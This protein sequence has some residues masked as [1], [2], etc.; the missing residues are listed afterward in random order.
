MET[1]MSGAV[2]RI[3]RNVLLAVCFAVGAAGGIQDRAV[4]QPAAPAPT[5]APSV[6]P[7]PAA[8]PAQVPVPQ[9]P[10]MPTPTGQAVPPPAS[11]AAPQL[12]GSGATTEPVIPV[13]RGGYVYLPEGRRD[14]FLTILRESGGGSGKKAEELHLPPLQ[15]VTVAELSVIG[16]I[17]GGFG[18][19]AMVQTSDGKGYTV[20]RGTRIGNNNGVVSAITEK[21]VIVEERFTDIYGKKQV[22]EYAK[23]LHAKEGLP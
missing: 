13:G 15:R 7:A 10:V 17:W 11:S 3:V 19:T 2:I 1:I 9:A 22:R 18:Y 4:A 12:G 20:Q 5:P 8:S 14:P 23:P 6:Q 16:I 21:A